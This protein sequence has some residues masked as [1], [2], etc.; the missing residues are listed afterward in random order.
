MGDEI[1]WVLAVNV[2]DGKGDDFRTLMEEMVASTKDEEGAVTYEWFVSDD[3]G[4]VH[5]YERYRDNDATMVHLG[6]FGANFA[7][8]FFGCV[9]QI[10]MWVYGPADDRV[11]AALGAGGAE[12]LGPY[13][14]FA[15]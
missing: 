15:R 3:G 2:K 9:D 4:Q 14:G 13:G 12:F 1:S 8:R 7:G 11:K 10:G 5:L 6:N